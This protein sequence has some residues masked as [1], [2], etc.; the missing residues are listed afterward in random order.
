MLKKKVQRGYGYGTG[1][2]QRTHS[3]HIFPLAFLSPKSVSSPE[4]T[5]NTAFSC[6]KKSLVVQKIRKT[7]DLV[8]LQG[9]EPWT[10]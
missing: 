3:L 10:P 4:A 1:N 5:V 7:S 9:L 6:I 8:H 2:I